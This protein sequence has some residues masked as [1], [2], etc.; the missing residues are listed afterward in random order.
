MSRTY[1]DPH[2]WRDAEDRR[3]YAKRAS[4]LVRVG[5]LAPGQFC[6]GKTAY[7]SRNDAIHAAKA[8]LR[9]TGKPMY[10]YPCPCCGHHHLTTATKEGE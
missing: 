5:A 9:D 3:E 2:D 4:T 10:P 7:P 8:V 6:L 1:R